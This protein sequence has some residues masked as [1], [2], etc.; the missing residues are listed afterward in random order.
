MIIHF[1]G[2]IGDFSC[3]NI[4][5]NNPIIKYIIRQGSEDALKFLQRKYQLAI[6]RRMSSTHFNKFEE[7]FN[8]HG[9][10]FDGI[11]KDRRVDSKMMQC[12]YTRIFKDFG[13]SVQNIVLGCYN[14]EIDSYQIFNNYCVG[15]IQCSLGKSKSI[16]MLVPYL[17]LTMSSPNMQMI[18]KSIDV[19]A[20][21]MIENNG[22]NVVKVQRIDK[23]LVT[24]INSLIGIQND[25]LQDHI[26]NILT[27]ER[28]LYKRWVE[29]KKKQLINEDIEKKK[30]VKS[31]MISNMMSSKVDA[32]RL[33]HLA[34]QYSKIVGSVYGELSQAAIAESYCE[35]ESLKCLENVNVGKVNGLI[36]LV[37]IGNGSKGIEI[38]G[39]E[40]Y[41]APY[42]NLSRLFQKKVP[43]T[44]SSKK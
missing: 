9:I 24:F 29:I 35:K 4:F 33:I 19:I 6:I 20:N 3:T 31:D 42:I 1:D 21:T 30:Q 17:G 23:T 38:I 11:Y 28:E 39:V 14:V 27:K 44:I 13:D 15:E 34:N 5:T 12:D 32:Y 26:N 16:T 2:V 41:L 40:K 37:G 25:Q 7:Y 36:V 8:K 10:E 43:M 18:C 22:L